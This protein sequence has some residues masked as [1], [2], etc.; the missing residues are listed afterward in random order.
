MYRSNVS[1]RNREGQVLVNPEREILLDVLFAE[2]SYPVLVERTI[3]TDWV[4]MTDDTITVVTPDLNSIAGDKL[5][6]FA[7]TTTG[8]P[9][10]LEKEREIIKQ[11]FD[12]GNIFPL[13]DDWTVFVQAY[14]NAAD[15]EIRYR[16]E[17][18]IASID[19]VLNDTIATA[20]IIARREFHAAD[21]KDSKD[22][23]TE[24]FR[25]VNQFT[26]F[27]FEGSFR[28]EHA[29]LASARAAYMAAIVLTGN[30]ENVAVFDPQ[31]PLQEYMVRH[32]DYN[33]LNKRLKAVAKGE[34]LFYWYHTL[35][36]LHPHDT[37]GPLPDP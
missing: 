18:N 22:K 17:R 28:I 34:A 15:S 3:K 23:Y 14:R 31:K 27:V 4:I 13:I 10:G 26:H 16:P 24:L 25:G 32:P 9:Y 11:L 33:F 21:D 30:T 7:P 37:D 12:V 1:S 35:A 20:L 19:A 6:A 2:N 29:Q 5:V 8:V 36:L